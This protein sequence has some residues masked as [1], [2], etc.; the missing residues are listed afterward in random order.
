MDR[1]KIIIVLI[2]VVVLIGCESI[3]EPKGHKT[4]LRNNQSIDRN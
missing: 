3:T 1:L 2:L 4:N